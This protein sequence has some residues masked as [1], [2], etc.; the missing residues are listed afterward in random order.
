[1]TVLDNN[2]CEVETGPI[3]IDM[4]QITKDIS[5]RLH[6]SMYARSVGSRESAKALR[7]ERLCMNGAFKL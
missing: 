1:M 5:H 2:M 7:Q 4:K 6:D 3:N